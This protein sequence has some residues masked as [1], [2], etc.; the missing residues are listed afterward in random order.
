MEVEIKGKESPGKILVGDD[1]VAEEKTE[2]P[3]KTG[4]AGEKRNTGRTDHVSL[5]RG[6]MGELPGCCKR[7]SQTENIYLDS[8]ENV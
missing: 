4:C 6:E 1:D 3:E 2:V 8:H 5:K 7:N